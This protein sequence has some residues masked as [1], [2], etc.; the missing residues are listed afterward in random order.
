MSPG[1]AADRASVRDGAEVLVVGAGPVGLTVAHEL[2]RRGIRIR[3]VD[4]APGP[5]DT[6]RALATH[7]RTLEIYDQMGVLDDLLARGRKVEHF[8][9]HR[10]GRTLIRFDT[11]YSRLATRFPFTLMVDQQITEEVLRTAL[12]GLGV[13]IEWGV[14]LT[15]FKAGADGVRVALA[16]A[17]GTRAEQ[18]VGW[19][20]GCDGGHSLVRK[21][22]GLPLI[23]DSSETWLIADAM[24]EV[25]LP[26]DSIHWM[27]VGGGTV[28]LVPFPE[29]GRWRLLDTAVAGDAGEAH[30]VG[31]RFAG[32]ISRALGRPVR[33]HTPTWVSVFSIQQRMVPAMGSGRCFV[34]GDAAHVHSPASGQGMNTGIQDGYNLAWKLAMAVRGLAGPGFLESYPAERV[35]IGRAL[36]SSTK[37]ATALV[38][39]RNSALSG[40]MPFGLA[41]VNAVPAVKSRIERTIMASMSGLRLGYPD[42]PLTGTGDGRPGPGDRVARFE[43]A[44]AASPGCAA[45]LDE[46]R[47]PRWTFLV[48]AD[49]GFERDA[50]SMSER[51]AAWLSVRTVAASPDGVP[52]RLA[53]PDGRLAAELDAAAGTWLLIRPDGYLA[54]RSG[55]GAGRALDDYC[56]EFGIAVPAP[57]AAVAR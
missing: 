45:L 31:R 23:G 5:A 11:D 52:G 24:V 22:L 48:F 7:A 14:E 15:G 25:D 17:D 46:L 32:K 36:L 20:V 34:A 18:D 12:A 57:G 1:E 53:D 51:H 16:G 41:F 6:S 37:N 39:L 26:Q 19:L 13:R 40:L 43:A 38:A 29:P 2:A 35:P 8:T 54:A 27:S 44:A 4:R 9:L 49:P 21:V 56:A 47:D 10:N 28:M 33:V 50:A 55:G 3:V 30:E 42:S